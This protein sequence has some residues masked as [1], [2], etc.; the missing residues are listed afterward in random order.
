M[1]KTNNNSNKIPCPSTISSS[2]R[3]ESNKL[4]YP[5]NKLF[6]NKIRAFSEYE[7]DSDIFTGEPGGSNKLSF[8]K[9]NSQDLIDISDKENRKEKKNNKSNSC[10]KNNVSNLKSSLTAKI[11]IS[12]DSN[13]EKDI[14]INLLNQK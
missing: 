13:K 4:L 2:E 11:N 6:S 1:S 14:Q 3:H 10:I 9:G 7:R 12:S 5:K 8:Y